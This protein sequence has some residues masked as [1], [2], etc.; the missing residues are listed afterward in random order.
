[1]EKPAAASYPIHDLIARRWSPRAFSDRRVPPEQLLS[2][3]E[4][5][6][7]AAS[8]F[9]EQP[10]EFI[11]ATKDEAADYE[12][13]ASCLSEGNRIW[14][15]SAPVLMLSIAKRFFEDGGEENRHAFHDVGMAMGNFL[16]QAT[17][18]GLFVHQMAGFDVERA[19]MLFGLPA[20]YDPVAMIALGYQGDPQSLPPKL[21]EREVALRTRKPLEKFVF[22]GRWGQTAAFVK[23]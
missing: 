11:V 19:R 9:N 8:S 1:M 23:R 18:L 21:R 2:L 22:S 4:A 13:L 7:W 6:R 15:T 14:A 3:L 20:G 10:W 16:L 5:A 12:R 17:A